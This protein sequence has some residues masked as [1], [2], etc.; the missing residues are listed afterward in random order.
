MKASFP[1]KNGQT[2]PD[3]WSQWN[4]DEDSNV[5]NI[6]KGAPYMYS[7]AYLLLIKKSHGPLFLKV[8]IQLFR[9]WLT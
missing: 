2:Q 9:V 1:L 8:F 4:A 6:R 3:Q 5:F 7:T